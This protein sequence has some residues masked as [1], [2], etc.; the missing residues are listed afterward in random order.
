MK[1]RMYKVYHI[2]PVGETDTSKFYIGITK[3]SLKFRLAQHMTS[4]R[5]VGNILRELGKDAIEI[6]MLHM[7]SKEEALRLEGEYRPDMNIGWN[8]RAGGNVRTVVCSGCGVHLPKRARGAMCGSCNDCRFPK[9]SVP[10]NAGSGMKAVL[11]SPEGALLSYDNLHQFCK[12]H[13]LIPA[14]VRKV[15]K[16][17][18]KHTKGWT[19]S[20]I[21]G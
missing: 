2:R 5:P 13:S 10:V 17:E 7:V 18:R 12:E 16:G 15:I 14:N 6:V 19:V 3:N 9:G 11:R 8:V 1:N 20:S 4:K 21:E